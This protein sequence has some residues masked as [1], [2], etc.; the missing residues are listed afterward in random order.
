M[1]CL[2]PWGQVD[3]DA[4]TTLL[5][6]AGDMS[7]T[8]H[9][10]MVS[11]S[12]PINHWKSRRLPPPTQTSLGTD[13]QLRLCMALTTNAPGMPAQPHLPDRVELMRSISFETD[14]SSL[15]SP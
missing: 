8:F 5:A 3:M 4:M 10:S 7:F 9:R 13:P 6:E 11:A 14:R 12:D 15:G 2:A 1:G